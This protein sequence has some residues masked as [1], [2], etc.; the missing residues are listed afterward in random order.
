[1]QTFV[2]NPH[3]TLRKAA[4]QT[5]DISKM[6]IRRILYINRILFDHL[7]RTNL[8][9]KLIYISDLQIQLYLLK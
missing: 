8:G 4:W 5:H 3:S 1:M 2:E 9:K 6:S 7:R